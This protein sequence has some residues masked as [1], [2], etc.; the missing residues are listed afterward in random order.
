[1]LVNECP[2]LSGKSRPAQKFTTEALAV[3]RDVDRNLTLA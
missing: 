2:R 1:M 3:L